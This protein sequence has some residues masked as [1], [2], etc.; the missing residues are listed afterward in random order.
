[1]ATTLKSNL[2]IPEVIAD[3]V[4]TKRGDRVSL[5][6]LAVQDNTLQPE[7]RSKTEISAYTEKRDPVFS[8][9]FRC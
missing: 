2:V 1:M 6:P 3:L 8:T 5:L 9:G 7:F 4:E